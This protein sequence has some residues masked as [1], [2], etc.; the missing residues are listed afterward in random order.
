MY[1]VYRNYP[2]NDSC[3]IRSKFK[4]FEELESYI[5]DSKWT[6]D[7]VVSVD[8][9][10]ELELESKKKDYEIEFLKKEIELLKKYNN[11]SDKQIEKYNELLINKQSDKSQEDL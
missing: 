5:N 1:Y 11:I 4:T 3:Y 7:I 10:K 2:S 8:I 6:Y 9:L